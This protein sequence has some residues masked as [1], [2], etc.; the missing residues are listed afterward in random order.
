MNKI[1]NTKWG[2][3]YYYQIRSVLC[4][5][6]LADDETTGEAVC[7]YMLEYKGAVSVCVKRERERE[8]VGYKEDELIDRRP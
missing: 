7:P 5:H 3:Y 4:C 6:L 8:R 2:N 1:L